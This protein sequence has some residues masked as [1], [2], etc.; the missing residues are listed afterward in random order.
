MQQLASR[1]KVNVSSQKPEISGDA[2]SHSLRSHAAIQ[3]VVDRQKRR[4][5]KVF[6][7]WLKQDPDLGGQLTIKFTILP[8]GGVSNVTIVKTTTNNASFDNSIIR[9]IMRWKFPPVQGGSPVEV[10]YPFVFEGSE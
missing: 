2:A 7:N 8:S 9:Y 4:L 3:K 6:E 10:V 1:G 5:I